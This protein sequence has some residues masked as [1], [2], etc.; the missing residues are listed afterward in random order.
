MGLSVLA[1]VVS[2]VLISSDRS[3]PAAPASLKAPDTSAVASKTMTASVP[4][5]VTGTT[6]FNQELT[7][8]GPQISEADSVTFSRQWLRNSEVIKGATK[9]NYRLDVADVGQEISVRV[10]AHK[11]GF[12][13]LET[14][15]APTEPIQHVKDVRTTVTYQVGQRGNNNTDFE[16]FKTE[17]ADILDDPRGWRADGIEFNEVESGAPMTIY[18]ANAETLPSFSSHCSANW[19]CRAGANVVINQSRWENATDTW[20]A[21][22]GTSLSGYRHMVVNHEVGHWLGLSHPGC[23][24]AGQKA[25]LMMQQSKGLNGCEPNPWPLSSEMNPPRFR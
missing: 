22:P 24:G 15:S 1:L 21:Q 25:P 13:P 2:L 4:P 12:E 10:V 20:N 11:E 5:T 6:R 19:S 7:H 23:G 8:D 18:L 17:V 3:A 9:P 14:T 16:A